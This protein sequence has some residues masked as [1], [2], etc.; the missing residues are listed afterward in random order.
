M[1]V[2]DQMCGLSLPAQVIC[3][4]SLICIKS[5]PQLSVIL[6]VLLVLLFLVL[7]F[8]QHF[9][10]VARIFFFMGEGGELMASL[11]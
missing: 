9:S 4:R 3:S 5:Q 7:E 10:Y 8:A 2:I 11:F 1:V 6:T